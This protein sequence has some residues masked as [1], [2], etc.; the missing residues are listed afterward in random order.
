MVSSRYSLVQWLGL[1]LSFTLPQWLLIRL[2]RGGSRIHGGRREVGQADLALIHGP[3]YSYGFSLGH[4][5][6]SIDG[7]S[8]KWDMLKIGNMLPIW[9][10]EQSNN[11]MAILRF[12]QRHHPLQSA[13]LWQAGHGIPLLQV[14]TSD[15]PSDIWLQ[16]LTD[17]DR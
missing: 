12:A 4:I 3:L 1:F 8:G 15:L 10:N 11:T 2:L 9:P 16:I 7:S 5:L 13:V 17:S 14:L 6:G